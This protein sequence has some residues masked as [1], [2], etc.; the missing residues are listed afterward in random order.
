MENVGKNIQEE[1]LIADLKSQYNLQDSA[2]V[3]KLYAVL[4][5]GKYVFHSKA[6]REFDDMVYEL[7]ME[8]KNNL[9][10]S[11][12]ASVA[13]KKSNLSGKAKSTQKKQKKIVVYTKGE[14]RFRKF[15]MGLLTL[16]MIGSFTYFGYYC[17]TA[18]QKNMQTERLNRLK[19][20]SQLNDMYE[21]TINEVVDEENGS[22]K[23]F[24]VLE[25][26]KSLYNKNKNLIGW[27][28]IDDTIIDYPVMQT[29][30][31]EFYL[32]HDIDQKTDKNGTLFLDAA[33]DI[34]KPSTNY[35]IYGHNM[36]SGKMFGSL[37]KY[38]N[39]EYFET[40]PYIIFDTIYEEAVY[41]V[42]YVFQ[43]QIYNEDEIVFKYY[44]FID[45][46]S[47]EEFDS[48]MSEM[49]KLSLYE[50]GVEA[51]YGDHLL[52]LSTCDYEEEDGRFVVVAK[53]TDR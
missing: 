37:S 34:T 40:H 41:E 49:E 26:Y 12:K 47:K 4:Q 48:N 8:A 30:D 43:S 3:L 11:G 27:L 45:A 2:A 21:D 1:Q 38:K 22:K 15:M 33:C 13:G 50:T 52:T 46:D 51:V 9:K 35:I 7:A 20:N 42:M 32:D 24:K 5:S 25:K 31:N 16:V 36:R 17:Y 14:Y 44:Q 39:Q 29:A 23:V 28:K 18:H 53:K 6:G 10:A 19:E